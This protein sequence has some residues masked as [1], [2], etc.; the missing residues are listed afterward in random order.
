MSTLQIELLGHF[1]LRQ[2]GEALACLHQPRQ[3]ALLAYLV[4]HR[5]A[6][7]SRQ[8]LAFLFWPDTSEAQAYANLRRALFALRRALP[9]VDYFVTIDAKRV[10]WRGDA[11]WTLDVAQFEQHMAEAKRSAQRG[12]T[13]AAQAHL[14]EAIKLYRGDL[15]PGCYDD[16]IGPERARLREDFLAALAQLS[17]GLEQARNYGAA[18][19]QANR[20]LLCDPLQEECYRRLMRLHALNGDRAA[21]LH[22][23][24]TCAA[25]LQ[26]EL[27]VE[28]SAPTRE[29]YAH[30]L[31]LE[32]LPSAP[33][34]RQGRRARD[35]LIGRHRE[36]QQLLWAWHHAA[37]GHAHFFLVGGEPGIGKTRLVEELAQWVGQQGFATAY[38]R[39]YA[40]EGRLALDPVAHWLQS[41]TVGQRMAKLDDLWLA[42]VAH[43]VPEVRMKR[44]SL[45]V[46]EPLRESWQRRHFFEAL[47]RAFL[48][49]SEPLLLTLDDLQWCDNE[50]LEWLRYLLRFDPHSPLLVVGTARWGEIDAQ[51][52]L[53]ALLRELGQFGQV[54]EVELA[55]LNADETVHLAQQVSGQPLAPEQLAAVYQ[56]SEGNPLLVQ[57]IVR[58]ESTRGASPHEPII[59]GV[60]LPEPSPLP[61]KLR[62]AIEIRLASLSPAARQLVELAATTGRSFTFALLRQITGTDEDHLVALLDGLWQRRIVR[63]QSN[64]TYDFSHDKI[65]EIAYRAIGPIRRRRLHRQVAQALE[66]LHADDLRPV[67][68]QIAAHYRQAGEAAKAA[69]YYLRTA[70]QL[71]FCLAHAET[72]ANL[73]HGLALLA[74]QPATPENGKLQIAMHSALGHLLSMYEGYGSLRVIAVYEATRRLCIA[75]GDVRQLIEAQRSLRVGYAV[76]G[77]YRQAQ[78]FGESNLELASRLGDPYEIERAHGGLGLLHCYLGNFEL[79]RRHLEQA[80]ALA[81]SQAEVEASPRRR[82]NYPGHYQHVMVLWVLGYPLAAQTLLQQG[83]AAQPQDGPWDIALDFEHCAV[84]HYLWREWHAM[85]EFARQ[86][87]KVAE[88]FEFVDCRWV[89]RVLVTVA[90]MALGEIQ[91]DPFLL[92][93]SIRAL[94]TQRNLMAVPYYLCM[95]ADVCGRLGRSA[96]GLAAL[97]EAFA[98]VDETGEHAWL[99]EMHRLRGTFLVALGNA[100]E[101]E[102]AFQQAVTVA[103]Q[104]GA[105]SLELRAAT[106]LA[107]LWQTQGR[108]TEAC[109]L[110][111]GVYGWF[112]EGFDTPDLQEA[113]AL[114]AA[115]A[116]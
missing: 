4:L 112:R 96:E 54:T 58:A 94:R 12:D 43:L 110:L 68:A 3:Q 90:A 97:D 34:S 24:H 18:I 72:M 79:S 102:A 111:S 67:S 42:Q 31:H 62:A 13:T 16:W 6:P 99:A 53:R 74:D 10:Q 115:L 19:R 14:D 2:D 28:P 91:G 56:A 85:R 73:Q 35:T 70:T 64:D 65:R 106:D 27:G 113:Q 30:L 47:A 22:L 69:D 55:P 81:A 37:H 9:V 33:P 84:I 93:Q 98:L 39:A 8:R 44:P 77:E 59:G 32:T 7:Q 116:A 103:R 51:H 61:A 60:A 21:A 75:T 17:D 1:H 88:E 40:A 11:P 15:L 87:L 52:P 101:A 66:Q 26:R 29:V 48:S 45:P 25:T 108:Q 36:W 83:L 95:V 78:K 20:L 89:G 109:S 23:Y 107:R 104:Q 50:T 49:V 92:Y 86:V 82:F 105:K 76:S 100:G 80:A 71:Q 114:L 46:A 5:H 38:T 63:E 41:E 57:E